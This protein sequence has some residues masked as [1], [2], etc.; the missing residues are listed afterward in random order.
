MADPTQDITQIASAQT[1]GAQNVSDAQNSIN[2]QALA[3]IAQLV[4]QS[5]QPAMTMNNGS[6]GNA[7]GQQLP[8]QAQKAA[9]KALQDYYDQHAQAVLS[10]PDGISALNA[11][12]NGQQQ[13]P[14]ST[15]D[16]V[17]QSGAQLLNSIVPNQQQGQNSPPKPQQQ[18]NQYPNT[19]S[20]Q[21]GQMQMPTGGIL[22]QLLAKAGIN[23]DLNPAG[24]AQRLQNA[25]S[26]QKINAG[27]PAEIALPQAQAG[28]AKAR[29]A[30]TGQLSK[31]LQQKMS[32]QEPLQA[33][34]YAEIMGGMNSL[35]LDSLKTASQKMDDDL[36]ERQAEID[37]SQKT[38]NMVGRLGGMFSGGGTTVTKATQKAQAEIQRLKNAK[39]QVD[40]RIATFQ[41]RNPIS[42]R[43]E[44]NA[45]QGAAHYSPST[46]KYYDAQGQEL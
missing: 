28:E 35:N 18:Q 23:I 10:H 42:A 31:E 19:Q 39:A 43:I 1:Q 29:T 38:I 27:Q 11:V 2:P 33:K 4:Q 15:P 7:Q 3:M 41:P 17:N 12:A 26:L 32:G 34:D 40:A 46:G 22:S 36:K 44:L 8:P 14:M 13:P 37:A 45:P 21:Q 24:T 6:T 25:A 30:Y 9:A 20:G 5:Q 16:G